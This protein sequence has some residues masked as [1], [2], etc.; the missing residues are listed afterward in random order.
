MR[1]KFLLQVI[2]KILNSAGVMVVRLY[3]YEKPLNCVLE[4]GEFYSIQI[5]IFLNNT[6]QF[7][8]V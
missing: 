1:V 7:C 4:T 2:K 5:I 8:G 3:I 6:P